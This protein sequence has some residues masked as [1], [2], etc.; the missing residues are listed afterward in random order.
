MSFDFGFDFDESDILDNEVQPIFSFPKLKE[1]LTS[2]GINIGTAG[3]WRTVGSVDI[4]PEDI[5]KRIL[6]ENNGIFYIDD[7]GVKRRGFMYKAAFYFEWNGIKKTPTFHVCRCAA[8]ENFGRDA[9][10]FANAEPIK[11]FARD[12]RKEAMVE[13]MKLCGFCRQML[14]EQEASRIYDSTDFVDILKEDG[15]VKEPTELDFFGYVK[16]WEQISFAFRQ[17]HNFTCERC[18]VHVEDGFDHQFMQTHHKNGD[19]TDNRPS[20]LECLCIECHANVDDTHRHNFSRGGNKVML[21]DFLRKYR[22]KQSDTLVARAIKRVK[23]IAS[24]LSDL[25]DDIELPF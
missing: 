18:G 8:I 24:D 1:K 12:K 16:D 13:G 2:M 14:L 23:G 4:L 3:A 19:K 5:G 11:V 10:R 25:D 17:K 7:E 21:E 6:F 22:G 15:D 9:Y 20:N